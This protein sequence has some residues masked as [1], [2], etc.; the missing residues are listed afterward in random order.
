MLVLP[1]MNKKWIWVIILLVLA[2]LAAFVAVEYFTTAIHALP[3]YIPGQKHG[4]GHYRKR[5]AGAAVI[6]FIL[7]VIAGIVSLRIINQEKQRNP[8]PVAPA[9]TSDD[10]LSS[11]P[12]PESP[13]DA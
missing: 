7:L 6:A 8:R 10:L 11:S 4:R 9:P 3:S 5:G 1:P 13:S 2:G 12:A